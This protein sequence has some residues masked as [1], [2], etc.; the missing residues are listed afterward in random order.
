MFPRRLMAVVL[1]AFA[2]ALPLH[3]GVVKAK[4]KLNIIFIVT[5]DQATWTTGAYGNKEVR[6]PNM[7]RLAREGAIFKNAFTV[8]PVCSPS[9]VS[10][11]TGKYGT[12]VKITDYISPPE[13]KAGVG[14][15]D[16]ALTWAEILRRHGY[17]TALIGKWHLGSLPQFHPTK[18]GFDHFFGFTGGGATP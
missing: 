11:M 14:V 4:R 16:S 18:H 17:L 2:F 10:F 7:D 5:D 1:A 12:Q 8:T 15:P 6:T 9:R 13:G 3:A